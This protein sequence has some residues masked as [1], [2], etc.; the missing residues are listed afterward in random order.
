MGRPLVELAS[1]A[2]SLAAEALEGVSG[3]DLEAAVHYVLVV[4]AP[5]H[6]LESIADIAS[7]VAFRLAVRGQGRATRSIRR[8]LQAIPAPSVQDGFEDAADTAHRAGLKVVG[9]H[10]VPRFLR[11]PVV[12]NALRLCD[13]VIDAISEQTPLG[14]PALYRRAVERVRI[15]P[16]ELVSIGM[17]PFAHVRAA[18]RLGCRAI[19]IWPEDDARPPRV[20]QYLTA[21]SLPDAV[22]RLLPTDGEDSPWHAL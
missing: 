3:R 9:A 14:T 1:M 17:D 12:K 11:S 8:A 2:M 18:T 6:R 21:A 13:V 10:G 5:R 4:D 16:R 19:L 22:R 15:R 7:Q 20:G